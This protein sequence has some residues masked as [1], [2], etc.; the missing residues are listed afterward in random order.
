MDRSRGWFVPTSR[1]CCQCLVLFR[2]L[3][4]VFFPCSSRVSSTMAL[5]SSLGPFRQTANAGSNPEPPVH[6]AGHS[7]FIAAIG[8]RCG[9]LVQTVGAY[10][11]R[12]RRRSRHG[13]HSG[14]PA[15]SDRPAR[16]RR[17]DQCIDRTLGNRIDNATSECQHCR[18]GRG[19]AVGACATTSHSHQS[20]WQRKRKPSCPCACARCHGCSQRRQRQQTCEG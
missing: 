18:S 1:L 2:P 3:C 7:H 10:A 17:H 16:R 8:T 19:R 20:E 13:S 11:T 15:T 14:K 9:S 12:A 6:A 4:L 5:L